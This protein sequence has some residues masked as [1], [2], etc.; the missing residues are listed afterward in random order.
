MPGRE[1]RSGPRSI[2]FGRSTWLNPA[3][4]S[5]IS[6]TPL[7]VERRQHFFVQVVVDERTDGRRR[8]SQ[9]GRRRRQ[10]RFEVMNVV[11]VTAVRFVEELPIESVST[12]EGNSHFTE[13]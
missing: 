9:R 4:L 11:V 2:A 12:E 3:D 13:V 5:A 1:R 10:P 6:R 8:G 7:G